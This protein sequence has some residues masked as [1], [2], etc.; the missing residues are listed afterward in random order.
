MKKILFVMVILFLMVPAVS[1]QAEDRSLELVI[2]SDKQVYAEGEPIYIDYQIHNFK[3]GNITL[4]PVFSTKDDIDPIQF[5][6]DF[7]L[8]GEHLKKP[9]QVSSGGAFWQE[10]FLGGPVVLKEGERYD[11]KINILTEE[12]ARYLKQ[13]GKYTVTAKYNGKDHEHY[14]EPGFW[15]GSLVSNAI[16]I[17]VVEKK[18]EKKPSV[19]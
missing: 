10:D 12:S 14:V 11:R 9:V 3:M 16:T 5:A 2:K 8:S 19:P 4:I 7:V 13:P 15:R 1:S 17:E 18:W 6:G